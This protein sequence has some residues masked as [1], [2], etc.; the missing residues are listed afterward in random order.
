MITHKTPLTHTS[1]KGI[2]DL[3]N[4]TKNVGEKYKLKIA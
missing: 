1:E 4:N 2:K 3:L